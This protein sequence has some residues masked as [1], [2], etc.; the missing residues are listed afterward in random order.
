[1]Q[2]TKKKINRWDVWNNARGATLLELLIAA[3]FIGI[4]S[5][6]SFSILYYFSEYNKRV[7]EESALRNEANYVLS[8]ILND[9]FTVHNEDLILTNKLSEL[10]S[11]FWDPT[12]PS[13]N[14]STY[15]V[16]P[17]EKDVLNSSFYLVG[18]SNGSIHTSK[19]VYKPQ[20]IVFAPQSNDTEFS[21]IQQIDNSN[22]YKIVLKLQGHY[23]APTF[24]TYL[25]LIE[26]VD[27]KLNKVEGDH[28]R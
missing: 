13:E 4:I 14:Y 18:F 7:T 19:E 2:K 9:M 5:I 28:K 25:R 10:K 26:D 17:K 24:I 23:T 1:M 16:L 21:Y 3:S 22:H 15:F 8:I 11:Q 12:Q 6:F 27:M 20:Y